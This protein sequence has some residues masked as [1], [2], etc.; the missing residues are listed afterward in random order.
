MWR[1][2]GRKRWCAREGQLLPSSAADVD[3]EL[4]L[5]IGSIPFSKL[6]RAG[7]LHPFFAQVI[8]KFLA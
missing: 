6:G 7:D 1:C 5:W 4:R 8:P 2:R 3:G